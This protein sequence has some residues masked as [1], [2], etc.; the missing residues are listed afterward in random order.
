MDRE[1]R[2]EFIKQAA[3][4]AMGSLLVIPLPGIQPNDL[5]SVAANYAVQLSKEVESALLAEGL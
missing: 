1:E 3:I 4:E 5:F 2:R